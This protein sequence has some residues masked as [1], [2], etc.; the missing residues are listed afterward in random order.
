L[1]RLR[2]L[3]KHR[4]RVRSPPRPSPRAIRVAAVSSRVVVPRRR[5]HHVQPHPPACLRRLRRGHLRRPR[6]RLRPVQRLLRP[7]RPRDPLVPFRHPVV[8]FPRPPRRVLCRHQVVRFRHRPVACVPVR[9]A[10][11]RVAQVHVPAAPARVAPVVPAVPVARVLVVQVARAVPVVRARVVPVV[12]PWVARAPVALAA[13]VRVAPVVR[14]PAV[15]AV[16]VVPV[17]RAAT[18]RTASVVR[19]ARS[20]APVAVATW[21]SCNR[22]S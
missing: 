19:R 12:R 7:R 5:P 2:P 6:A 21:K 16:P 4:R 10:P 9:P 13:R 17:G 1:N 20:R 18:V 11:D 8:R 15:P 22:S 14:V 3:R